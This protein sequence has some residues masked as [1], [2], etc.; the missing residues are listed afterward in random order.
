MRD[1]CSL[2]LLPRLVLRGLLLAAGGHSRRHSGV[3]REVAA[4]GESVAGGRWRRAAG[5]GDGGEVSAEAGL[6]R[7]GAALWMLFVVAC[8]LGCGCGGW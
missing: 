6:N 7:S 4:V 8:G 5:L 2:L 1:A 3:A